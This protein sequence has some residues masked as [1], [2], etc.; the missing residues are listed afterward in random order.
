MSFDGVRN[1][2]PTLAAISSR[3]PSSNDAMVPR[4]DGG[5]EET[6]VVAPPSGVFTALES[7]GCVSQ[8]AMKAAAKLKARAGRMVVLR[9]SQ[10]SGVAVDRNQYYRDVIVK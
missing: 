1:S 2:G 3:S 5:P 4:Q 6:V 10:V 9:C 7:S 8:A